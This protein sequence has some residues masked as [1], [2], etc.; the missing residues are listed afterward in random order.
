MSIEFTRNE[1]E[2]AVDI[3]LKFLESLKEDPSAF[4]RFLELMAKESMTL[5]YFATKV[6]ELNRQVEEMTEW[7]DEE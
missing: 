2:T 4:I 5:K 6:A 3:T 1:K 7:R